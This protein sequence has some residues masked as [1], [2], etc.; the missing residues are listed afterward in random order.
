[1]ATLSSP[2]IGS[3]LDV[4]TIVSQLMAAER[5]PLTLLTRQETSY[6]AKLSAFGALKSALSTFQQAAQTLN[7]SSTFANIKSA[8]ADGSVMTA[9]A[10]GVATAGSYAIEVKSLAQAQKLVSAGYAKATTVVGSGTL[11]LDIGSYSDAATPPVTFSAAAGSKPTTLT[12]DSSN[13]TLQ[14]IRDAINAAQAGVS[15]SLI[16]DGNGFRLALTATESG[17]SKTVRIGVA[18]TGGAGLAQLAYDGSAGSGLTQNVAASNAVIKVD[19]ITVTKPSNT[20]TDAVQ[21]ITLN[22]TKVTAAGVTTQ[23]TLTR[24]TDSVAT[25]IDTLVK[26]YNAVTKQI[27]E[28]TAYNIA[29]GTGSVLTGDATARTLQAQLRTTMASAVGGAQV[30]LATLSDLGIAFQSDGTLVVDAD[31]RAKILADPTRDVKKLFITSNDGTLGIGARMNKLVS[32]MIFGNDAVLNGKVDGLNKAI[33]DIARQRD[34]QNVRLDAIE[35]R[36]NKQ[37]S[38]LDTMISSMTKTSAFLTQQISAFNA[39]K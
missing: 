11:T 30:G 1:V 29:T 26:S 8:V 2:G 19:G 10:N 9:A 17:L 38:A 33:K 4:K 18:E 6:N 21:G 5:Q 32:G 23:L 28:A 3:N 35:A 13:N 24:D 15:A 27:A 36:Y 37:F 25:A 7:L 14:G 12:I 16:N 22:L 20:I 34:S 39:N 31:K